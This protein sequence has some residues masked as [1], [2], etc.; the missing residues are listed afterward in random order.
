MSLNYDAPA[1]A[2]RTTEVVC[3]LVELLAERSDN[4]SPTFPSAEQLGY[5]LSDGI[6]TVLREMVAD[7][8]AARFSGES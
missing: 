8:V 1:N 3:E 5:D 2:L 4:E 7:R 6:H